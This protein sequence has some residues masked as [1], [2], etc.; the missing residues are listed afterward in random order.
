MTSADEYRDWD[1][2]YVMGMLC[3]EE[4][5]EYERHLA[6]CHECSHA[7][8]EL[9]GM[10]GVLG[11]LSAS[12]AS[13][14]LAPSVP[15]G[16]PA[17]PPVTSSAGPPAGS[18]QHLARAVGRR[19]RTVRRR[20][21]AAV[22]GTGLLLAGAGV[23]TGLALGQFAPGPAAT[24]EAGGAPGGTP[25]VD[26]TPAGLRL[27]MGQVEP[28]YIDAELRVSPKDWGTRFDWD[29]SYSE[30]LQSALDG[31]VPYDL[32]VTD[33]SGVETTVASWTAEKGAAAGNLSASTSIPAAQIA[34]VDIR[35]TGSDQ[36]IVRTEL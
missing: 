24:A 26:A 10:P 1:A 29:C 20:M 13:A 3:P 7:V 35:I 15:D 25:G 5:R 30:K 6:D 22:V 32:V 12:E 28:G 17:V 23:L 21:A 27:A 8:A 4:R 11:S 36:P 33:R 18:V 9:A 31:P 19:R 14:L 34:S 2:A 16:A